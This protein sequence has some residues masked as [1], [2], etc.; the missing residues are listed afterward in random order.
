[1]VEVLIN[2]YT[3]IKRIDYLGQTSLLYSALVL[4]L[5][6]G[7]NIY[8]KDNSGNT[9]LHIIE[10]RYS[11]NFGKPHQLIDEWIK[12]RCSGL[13]TDH[14]LSYSKHLIRASLAVWFCERTL[15]QHLKSSG[16]WPTK[17]AI[18]LNT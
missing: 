7:T 3:D 18:E 15:M 17:A 12:I 9:T 2:T 8:V 1:M 5:D 6:H 14:V 4:L 16:P 13:M 11:R 10:T